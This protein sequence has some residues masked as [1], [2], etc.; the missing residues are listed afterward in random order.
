MLTFLILYCSNEIILEKTLALLFSFFFIEGTNTSDK[1]TNVYFK[2]TSSV[3]LIQKQSQE[4]PMISHHGPENSRPWVCSIICDPTGLVLFWPRTELNFVRTIHRMCGPSNTYFISCPYWMWAEQVIQNTSVQP[5][6]HR[7]IR[8]YITARP[9]I[10][11]KHH[12]WRN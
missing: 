1:N 3:V 5:D 7:S 12:W 10:A 11:L 8:L 9:D 2:R 4:K 6:C